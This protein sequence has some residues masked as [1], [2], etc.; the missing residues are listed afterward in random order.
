MVGIECC[1]LLCW[2]GVVWY[3]CNIVQQLWFCVHRRLLLVLTLPVAVI[4]CLRRALPQYRI[5]HQLLCTMTLFCD[6][7]L[8]FCLW[9]CSASNAWWLTDPTLDLHLFSHFFH[10]VHR[11]WMILTTCYY[12]KCCLTLSVLLLYWGS[13][14]RWI[15]RWYFDFISRCSSDLHLVRTWHST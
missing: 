7:C 5:E 15:T 4:L 9:K 11:L 8:C 13:S 6:W 12:G 3:L 2:C 10:Y 14:A 1:L